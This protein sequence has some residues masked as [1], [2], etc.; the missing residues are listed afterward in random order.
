MAQSTNDSFPTAVH[1]ATLTMI[2]KLLKT[3]QELKQAFERKAEE[4]DSVIK[5]GRT[6]L[7]DAVPIRL[8]QEFQA[9]ARVLGR[10]IDRLAATKKNLL[11]IN[12][13]ATAVGT[14]LNADVRYIE[15]VAKVLAELSGFP[16][17]RR[18]IWSM[19]PKTPTRTPKF[20]P[21]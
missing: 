21:R 13:G 15:H 18:T 2:E 11:H 16:I 9:Y 19:P 1:L 12:M 20:R 8:G 14:G 7:Q 10:D 17:S 6:H 5:M 4:F 3:M